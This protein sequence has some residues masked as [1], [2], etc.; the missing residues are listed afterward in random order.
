MSGSAVT[1]V[2]VPARGRALLP[3]L[4]ETFEPLGGVL[5][6]FREGKYRESLTLACVGTFAVCWLLPRLQRFEEAHP[7]VDL[8]I[9]THNNRVDL[10]GD[11]LD[12]AIRFGNGAWHGT[13]GPAAARHAALARLRANTRSA[14]GP[15]RRPA[16]QVVASFYRQDEWPA[17]FQAA[18]VP[19]PAVLRGP[20]LDSC[21]ALVAAAA[22]GAGAALVPVRLFA[23]DLA[24]GRLVQP[25][26]IEVETGSYWLTQLQSRP[27][28]S[29][30]KAFASWVQAEL[31]PGSLSLVLW[32]QWPMRLPGM[33]SA[34]R[35]RHHEATQGAST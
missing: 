3:V 16:G 22:A 19:A 14:A 13:A 15:A 17:W 5:D 34:R 9:L 27:P 7:F 29:A 10:A 26:S 20:K 31:E 6:Q 11:G 1:L 35:R 28:T 4:A 12:L 24:S 32:T 18:G 25:F 33:V 23:P 21:V 8:R 2:G 30:I